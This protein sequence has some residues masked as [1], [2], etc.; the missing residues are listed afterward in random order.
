[1]QTLEKL[2]F[3]GKS[4]NYP[5]GMKY[6]CLECLR[7]LANKYKKRPDQQL[8]N[9]RYYLKTK[10]KNRKRNIKRFY[11]LE[12]EEFEL[13]LKSQNNCCAICKI[14]KVK[15]NRD[16]DV[17]HCHR[18]NKVRGLLCSNCNRAIGLLKEDIKIVKELL[19]YLTNSVL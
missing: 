14:S 17:D 11:N 5:D 10:F 12:Y 16:L 7:N 15:L 2:E 8:R 6:S 18:T 19:K 13:L 4:K 3:F 9:R 1:L